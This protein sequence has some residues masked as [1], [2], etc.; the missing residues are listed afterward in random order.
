MVPP[1]LRAGTSQ[2]DIPTIFNHAPYDLVKEVNEEARTAGRQLIAEGQREWP[3]RGLPSR[4][5]L[6]RL[7]KRYDIRGPEGRR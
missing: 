4:F 1:G 2:R 7:M 3:E 5:A 6:R